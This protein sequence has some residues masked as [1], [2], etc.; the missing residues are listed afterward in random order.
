M[1]ALKTNN[2]HLMDHLLKSHAVDIYPYIYFA[3]S[4]HWK[5]GTKKAVCTI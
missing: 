1:E 2:V 4:N 5:D 3:M